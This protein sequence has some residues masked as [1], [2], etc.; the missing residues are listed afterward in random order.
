VYHH[1]HHHQQ[2]QQQQRDPIFL[3]WLAV[4]IEK[5]FL[6]LL[7]GQKQRAAKRLVEI[8]RRERYI[9]PKKDINEFQQTLHSI[10]F[11]SV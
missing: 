3:L 2:Q 9:D 4:Q 11:S 5:Y 1:H 10:F 7:A 8:M 6:N